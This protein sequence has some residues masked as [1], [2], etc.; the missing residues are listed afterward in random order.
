V[1]AV[2]HA[3]LLSFRLRAELDRTTRGQCLHLSGDC[4]KRSIGDPVERASSAVGQEQPLGDSCRN[5]ELCGRTCVYSLRMKLSPWLLALASGLMAMTLTAEPPNSG[6]AGTISLSPAHGGPIRE[7]MPNSKPLA[8][9][10]FV[11]E[12]VSGTVATFKTDDQ[13]KFS[14]NLPPGHYRVSRK[15][16]ASRVGRFGPFEVDVTAGQMA[17]VEWTCDSGMR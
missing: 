17:E 3:A 8:Q 10:E 2:R 15:D 6:I 1:P 13:G 11:V 7:G 12:N 5:S 14:V 4:F 16:Y 9:I